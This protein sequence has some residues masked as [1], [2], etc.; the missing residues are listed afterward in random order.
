MSANTKL[1][2]YFNFKLYLQGL[3]RLRLTGLI[4]IIC[5]CAFSVLT[6]VSEY[7]TV[8]IAYSNTQPPK[9]LIV[10]T[11][12]CY[13]IMYF[14]VYL[15][16]PIMSFIIWNYL[17]HRNGSDFYHSV[18]SKRKSVF[19]SFFAAVIT[20]AAIIIA[21][22]L[23]SVT[24]MYLC[25][26]SIYIINIVNAITF[27]INVFISSI[28]VAST[29]ALGCSLSGT[30]FSNLTLST[31]IL[32]VPRFITTILCLLITAWNSTVHV[33]DIFWLSAHTYNLPVSN[34]LDPFVAIFS[35]D[36]F[37]NTA[38]FRFCQL[39]APTVYTLVL[40]IIYIIL[41]SIAYYRRPSETAGKSFANKWARRI[42][43]T[44]TG[45]GI[46]LILV[47]MFYYF[48]LNY[49][50]LFDITS[51]V[52]TFITFV[53]VFFMIVVSIFIYSIIT[54]KSLKTSLKSLL[55]GPIVLALDVITV[56]IMLAVNFSLLSYTPT[57]NDVKYVKIH[58]LSDDFFYEMVKDATE[59]D[60]SSTV[61]WRSITD[62]SSS[63]SGLH[64]IS[65]FY[66]DTEDYFSNKLSD[67][68]ITDPDIIAALCV[69]L[70]LETNDTLEDYDLFPELKDTIN[71]YYQGVYVTFGNGLFETNR[72][73]FLTK[74]TYEKVLNYMTTS[75]KID[76]I[77]GNLPDI[78]FD[79]YAICSNLTN[80]QVNEIYRT[81]K[82]ELKDIDTSTFYNYYTNSYYTNYINV[83]MFIDGSYTKL[84]L[85]ITNAT[86]KAFGLYLKYFNQQNSKTFYKYYD[87]LKNDM[88]NRNDN[89]NMYFES[90]YFNCY[91]F[92]PANK[93]N[94]AGIA[95]ISYTDDYNRGSL[96]SLNALSEYIDKYYTDMSDI[97]IANFDKEKYMLCYVDIYISAIDAPLDDF[98]YNTGI[99]LYFLLD[100]TD[101]NIID[102][103]DDFTHYENCYFYAAD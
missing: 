56:V 97:D 52:S 8:S 77:L 11:S 60:G 67:I 5:L 30:I 44:L 55:L 10:A 70:E 63:D 85:P 35:F 59:S 89:D 87:I 91:D 21:A 15:I 94:D 19:F 16:V 90:M 65:D 76:Y 3:K 23:V 58:G 20:W 43:T 80:S 46:S 72:E 66:A 39:G 42:T 48:V 13:N 7:I 81:Y 99:T 54:T 14:V 1:K 84:Q 50:E 79:T 96:S 73:I 4:S 27:S 92:E 28:L 100:K 71:T 2:D 38:A 17:N 26:S 83:Y 78:G 74:E 101:S 29:F 57:A 103:L 61:E 32:F 98:N 62:N 34:I 41:G 51:L 31:C 86:P 24:I 12:S 95:Y 37:Y 69:A 18:A 68:K 102:L 64:Y 93:Y 47:W 75:E 88:A 9:N 25:F 36:S 45:Y 22:V 49:T 6:I 82:E 53:I 40:A 33:S